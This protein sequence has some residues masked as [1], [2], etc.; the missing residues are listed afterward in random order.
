MIVQGREVVVSSIEMHLKA[1][2]DVDIRAF[3]T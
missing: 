1:D 3:G 2:Y